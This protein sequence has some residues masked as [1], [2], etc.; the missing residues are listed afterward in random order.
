MVQYVLSNSTTKY[1]LDLTLCFVKLRGPV[2]EFSKIL[3]S[4]F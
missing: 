3:E 2:P 4:K 1:F